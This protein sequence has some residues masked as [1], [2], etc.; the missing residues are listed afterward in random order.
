VVVV[1]FEIGDS[2]VLAVLMWCRSS[3]V[4]APVAG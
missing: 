2:V 3:M 1:V 4:S